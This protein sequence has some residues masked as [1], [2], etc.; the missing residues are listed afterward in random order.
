MFSPW[1]NIHKDVENPHLLRKMIYFYSVTFSTWMKPPRVETFP[2]GSGGNHLFVHSRNFTITL[3]SPD[4][5]HQFFSGGL[6]MLENPTFKWDFQPTS[7]A[8]FSQW[9][10]GC[11]VTF[12]SYGKILDSQDGQTEK[13]FQ[14]STID[15]V[16]W[17][18]FHG[19]ILTRK[20]MGF[21]IKYRGFRLKFSRHPILWYT[22]R[23]TLLY[24]GG[25]PTPLK[26]MSS[27]DWIIIPNIGENQSHVPNHQPD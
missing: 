20:P 10:T 2:A 3:G 25:I 19:K 23:E 7:E 14:V 22:L 1:V 4:T 24:L 21:T 27:S 17:I 16:Q 15:D 9:M 8:G 13:I 11:P 26:N 6:P 12:F 18:G 5:N